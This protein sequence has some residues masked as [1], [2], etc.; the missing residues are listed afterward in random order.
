MKQTGKLGPLTT[1]HKVTM[2]MA[3]LQ[4]RSEYFLKKASTYSW[5][6]GSKS[7]LVIPG[8]LANQET[9][10]E[11]STPGIFALRNFCS[12]SFK[13]NTIILRGLYIPGLL[14]PGFHSC[15]ANVRPVGGDREHFA[16]P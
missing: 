5:A 6:P 8:R 12:P 15:C 13:N 14:S 7:L 3:V 1:R 11:C 9:S 2:G 4:I 10:Q 16:L